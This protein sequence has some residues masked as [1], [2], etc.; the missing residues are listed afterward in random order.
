MLPDSPRLTIV[1]EP[2]LLLW[3]LIALRDPLGTAD[4]EGLT[5][6]VP[7]AKLFGLKNSF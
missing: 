1:L 5:F 2:N 7:K 6:A 4:V 3:K